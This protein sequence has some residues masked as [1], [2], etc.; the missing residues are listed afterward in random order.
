M[1]R[2]PPVL[3]TLVVL[4]AVAAMI[5]LGIWQLQRK[6]WKEAMLA[7]FAAADAIPAPLV[8][9]GADLPQDAGFRHIRWSCPQT[10][11]DQVVGGTN[12]AGQSGWAHVVLCIHRSGDAA[13]LLPVVLGWSMSV[14]PVQWTGGVLTGIAVPG[15]K[16]GVVLPEASALSRN[17]DWHIVADPPLAGL[18]ANARPDLHDIPNNHFAYAIQWFCFAATALVI[19]LL[20]LRKR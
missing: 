20:A 9:A 1:K 16:S 18:A 5:G 2:R 19:Y 11:A 15:I 17:L 7:R 13:T 3:A 14:A 6:T 10:S 4:L 12:A 8:I